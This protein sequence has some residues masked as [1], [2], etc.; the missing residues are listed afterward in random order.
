MTADLAKALK[1]NEILSLSLN[2]RKTRWMRQEN[3]EKPRFLFF[4]FLSLW[5]CLCAHAS[6]YFLTCWIGWDLVVGIVTFHPQFFSRYHLRTRT[7]CVTTMR[8]HRNF[9]L[10]W[11]RIW[12]SQVVPLLSFR[13][14]STTRDSV[15]AP[16]CI[17]LSC[18]WI[19]IGSHGRSSFVFMTLTL[20]KPRPAV[21]QN[22]PPFWIC[23]ICSL[24]FETKRL[25]DRRT[26]G[27]EEVGERKGMREK[28]KDAHDFMKNCLVKLK[29]IKSSTFL[30]WLYW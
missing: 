12:I 7:F 17:Y 29:S 23:L 30:F 6:V 4:F 18:F 22:I 13:V 11:Y 28:K 2:C 27:E 8:D 1:R 9:M 3:K 26:G 19:C 25:I 14:F 10:I 24:T 5:V 16:H 15:T 20:L 21:L